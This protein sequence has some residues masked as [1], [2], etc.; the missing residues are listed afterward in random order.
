MKQDSFYFVKPMTDDE[1]GMDIYLKQDLKRGKNFRMHWHEHLQL[2]VYLSGQSLLKCGTRSYATHPGSVAVINSNELHYIESRS[3]E[4]RFYIIWVDLKSLFSRPTDWCQS[5]YFAPLSENRILFQNMIDN[6][7]AFDH[8]LQQLIDAFH[9]RRIG[10][11][12]EVRALFCMLIVR[13]LRQHVRKIASPQQAASRTH[14]MNGFK[15]VF[16]YL[17]RHYTE[18]VDSRHLADIMHM[19][20][21]HYCRTFKALTGKTT[22]D[23]V[24]ELRLDQA[25]DMLKAGGHTMTEVALACG[26]DDL[27]Y[28]SRRFKKTYGC[29]PSAF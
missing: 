3:D 25:A 18:P 14:R 11:E 19:S 5:K 27:N 7:P 17:D 2:Y 13:L 20:L 22:T 1:L 8:T 10:F 15:A 12:I 24:N 9:A 29:A 21:A 28:F 23:Y 26:F 4:L 6:D 16:D